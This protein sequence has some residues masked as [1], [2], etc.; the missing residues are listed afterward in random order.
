ML[1]DTHVHL[2]F[3][4]FSKSL[5][6]TISEAKKSGVKKL[7]VPGSNLE[8][9]KKA[10]KVAEKFEGVFASVGV[11][12]HHAK[13]VEHNDQLKKQ[14]LELASSSQVVA[15][16]ECGLDYYVYK[17]TKYQN[18]KITPD[19]KKTQKELLKMHF[20]VAHQLELPLILHNRNAHSDII[21]LIIN[22]LSLIS[23]G[24]VMHCISG[25]LNYLNQVLKLGFYAG[26][27]GN[28]TY[29]KSVQK[30]AKNIPLNRLLLETDSPYLTPEPFRGQKNSP[31]NVKIVAQFLAKIRPESESKIIVQT[32][33]N[34]Q[35]LFG[36]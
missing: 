13:E 21:Q 26:V 16:G 6:N 35:K 28:V 25:S 2:N 4:T 27:D 34:A 12:P 11:H 20:E 36:I 7:I 10:V 22:H 8:T 3:K 29:S 32:T 19:F 5:K 23:A 33:K 17:K 1:I 30:L 18:Y 15:V 9:S 14:L 31:K 24:A